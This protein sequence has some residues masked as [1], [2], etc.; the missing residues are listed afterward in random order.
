MQT[1]E[2]ESQR[3]NEKMARVKDRVK[4]A[5]VETDHLR[6]EKAEL[7]KNVAAH[8]VEADDGRAVELCDWCVVL[9]CLI[10]T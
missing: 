10:C 5:T 6:S 7:E 4:R 9:P 3:V 8:K 2:D 1:M